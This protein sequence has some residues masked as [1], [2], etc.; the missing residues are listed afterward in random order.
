M[1]AHN[2]LTDEQ[3]K[4]ISGKNIHVH[5][6]NGAAQKD[7]PSAGISICT[8]YLSLALNRTIPANIAMTGEL[9]T[10]GEVCKI[11]KLF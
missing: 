3:I 8:A 9:S 2:F 4:D 10:T 11:G 7:G 5:F 1:N 6:T